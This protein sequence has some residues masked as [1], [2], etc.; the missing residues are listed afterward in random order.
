[1]PSRR[2]GGSDRRL[3]ELIAQ[4]AA[5]LIAEGG[6]N[7]FAFAK[8]KA[9]L[10]LGVSETNRNLPGNQEVEEALIT[11]QRLFRADIQP[12]RL[13]AL[14]EAALQAMRM[15][16]PFRPRLV[17]AVLDGTADEHSPVRLHLFAE[18]PERVDLF[19]MERGIPFHHDERSYRS[20]PEVRER[21]PLI[22]FVAGDVTIELTLFPEQ[23]IRQPPLSPTDGR[24]MRR[25]DTEAVAALLASGGAAPR[26][27]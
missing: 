13:Q 10:R 26:R 15:L 24:P 17:G 16:A 8:R 22:R 14:R 11:H 23:G 19:L 5:R 20:S 9:A 18:T 27:D 4:E 12:R 21:R 25:A 1:M 7:D 6:I 2:S 3:R